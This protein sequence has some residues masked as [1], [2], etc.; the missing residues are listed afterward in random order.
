MV[1]V[2]I[3][4]A[5][6]VGL[7]QT[8]GTTQNRPDF[9]GKWSLVKSVVGAETA[10]GFGETFVATQYSTSLIVDW[11]FFARGRGGN[12]EQRPVHE[13]FI[14]DGT[15]SNVADIYSNSGRSHSKIVDTSI[16]D[17][18]RLVITTTW[19]CNTPTHVT[20]KRILWLGSDGTLIVETSTPPA[21]GG[22]WSSAQS[23]YRR[24][25][26]RVIA[27]VVVS[28]NVLPNKPLQPTS[29]GQVELE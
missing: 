3:L 26:G 8:G 15:E 5:L 6:V 12:L 19:R 21:G 28:Q 11:V 16:W 4:V 2:P 22:P 23:R 24:A 25:A 14:F 18:E 10:G 20:R 7:G 27:N 9:G 29:G 1:S 13:A 17:G